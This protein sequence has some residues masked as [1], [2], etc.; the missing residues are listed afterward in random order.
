MIHL[1][2]KNEDEL[3][4]EVAKISPITYVRA[5]APP[6]LVMHGVLDPFVDVSQADQFVAALKSVGARDVTYYRSDEA[7]HAVFL[8]DQTQTF[9]M[10]EDFFARTLGYPKGYK[11]AQR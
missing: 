7:G 11:V 4:T 3:K 8:R 1:T 5:D 9:P 10:M 2:W 6:M